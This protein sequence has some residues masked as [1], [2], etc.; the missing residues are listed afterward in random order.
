M[1]EHPTSEDLILRDYGEQPPA[2]VARLDDHLATC[3]RCQTSR[4]E[5]VELLGLVNHSVPEEP[6]ADFERVIWARVQRA[7]PR[8]RVWSL[9]QWVPLGAL[10]ALVLAAT[11]SLLLRAP[12]VPTPETVADASDPVATARAHRR[13]LFT[14]LNDHFT[15]TEMLLVEVM[16]APDGGQQESDFERDTAADLVASGRCI[17]TR[18]RR[19]AICTSVAVL[20]DLE[21][22]LV[23]VARGPAAPAAE[24]VHLLRSRIDAGD[25]L[26]KVRAV[27]TEIRGHQP[28]PQAESE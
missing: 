23:D 18:P 20:D 17:A 1:S 27:T 3:S 14:A 25:L 22:V 16:N 11:G 28:Q 5:L 7:L 15:Q 26:F 13:V 2:D 19:P 21:S 6:P 10:A 4:D 8:Q 12:A 24:D 9:R